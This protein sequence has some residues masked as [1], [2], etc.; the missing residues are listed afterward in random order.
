MTNKSAIGDADR[1]GDVLV[2]ILPSKADFEIL[3]QQGWYRIPVEKAP[4][5]WP[6]RWLAFY[7]PKVFGSQAFAVNYYGTVRDIWRV[8]R[9]ELFP[10]V[11]HHPMAEREYYKIRLEGLKLLPRPIVSA[12][13]RRIVFIP[14]TWSKFAGAEE[15][16]DLYD[17]SP[18]EDDLWAELK[19]LQIK[20]E[21]QWLEQ[22]RTAYY[23][24]DFA[25]FCERGRLDIE[26]DGD[27]YHTPPDRVPLDNRRFNDL[28]STGW[29]VIRFNG[30]Q[31]REEMASYCIPQVVEA[32]SHLGGASNEG[33]IPRGLSYSADG[34]A[35][36]LALFER[37]PE[38]DLD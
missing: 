38:Y 27:T 23:L 33:M 8:K 35:Q 14:T 11:P 24:L 13:W 26:T 17:G 36:Q 15:I 29:R 20:A 28:Q 9:R 2:A 5:R 16:N 25:V 32:I 21:R 6:P 7:Q 3:H 22:V 10:D 30:Q 19:A 37:G 34:V 1:R 12:R 18:L 31:I 4:K